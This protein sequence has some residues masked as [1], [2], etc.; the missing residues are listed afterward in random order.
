MGRA[1]GGA[2]HGPLRLPARGAPERHPDSHHDR[3]VWLALRYRDSGYDGSYLRLD[4]PFAVEDPMFNGIW[5]ASCHA[6][7]ELAA[8]AGDD[9]GSTRRRPRG[10]VR[11]CWTASGPTACSTPATCAATG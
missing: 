8:A 7:A 9:P 4:H 3:Y 11:R 10:S 6:L 1:A 5:L 2:A